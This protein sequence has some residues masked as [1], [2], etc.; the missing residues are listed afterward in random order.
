MQSGGIPAHSD[1]SQRARRECLSWSVR[2]IL[3]GIGFRPIPRTIEFQ[4]TSRN[5]GRQE[6]GAQNIPAF[7]IQW[8]K[9]AGNLVG[10]RSAGFPE[11]QRVERG[12]CFA[13]VAVKVG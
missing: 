13:V 3:I 2:P 9:S 1:T 5:T 10:I 6:S 11:S 12:S 4:G 8:L 7:S